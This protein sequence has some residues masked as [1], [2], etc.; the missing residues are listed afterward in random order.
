M[1]SH[2]SS[3]A[4]CMSLTLKSI[5]PTEEGKLDFSNVF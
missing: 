1:H 5:T 4:L 3:V 2:S